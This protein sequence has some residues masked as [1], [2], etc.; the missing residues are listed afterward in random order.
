MPPGSMCANLGTA[1]VITEHRGAYFGAAGYV[2]RPERD[3][4][5]PRRRSV[6]RKLIIEPPDGGLRLDPDPTLIQL[7]AQARQ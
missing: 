1:T 7:V 3:W 2:A 4:Q 6:E 5:T